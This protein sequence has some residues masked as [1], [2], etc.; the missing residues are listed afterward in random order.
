MSLREPIKLSLRKIVGPAGH[1]SRGC[2]RHRGQ[3]RHLSHGGSRREQFAAD[4]IEGG[5][6]SE[7]SIAD[8]IR[9]HDHQLRKAVHY[10]INLENKSRSSTPKLRQAK[11][12]VGG[13]GPVTDLNVATDWQTS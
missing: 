3:E 11:S 4:I 2:F 7:E 6:Q 8:S 9:Y 13:E 5:L 12:E 10:V 1:G